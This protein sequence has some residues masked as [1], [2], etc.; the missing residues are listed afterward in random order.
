MKR[1]T[2][3]ALGLALSFGAATH[4]SA[5]AVAITNAEIHTVSGGVIQNGTI[6]MNGGRITAIGTAVAI[7]GN[8]RTID[9]TGKIVTPGFIDPSSGLGLSEIPLGA[10]GASDGA[11]SEADLGASFNPVWA[12]NPAA[13]RIP[14]TRIRGVTSSVVQPGGGNLFTG[15]GAVIALDGETV[16]DMI[17]NES[18]AIYTAMGETGSGRA[19]GSRAANYRRLHDALWDARAAAISDGREDDE[20]AP[21][22]PM[23][24]GGRSKLDERDLEALRG[25]IEGRVP[26]VVTA[27]R[28]S[29]IR[30]ALKLEAEFDIRMVIQGGAEGWQ[31][32]D[33]LAANGVPVI[34][35]ATTNLPTMDGL[36]AS[37]KNAGLM[38]AA[39]VE[40]LLTGGRDMTHNAG[41]AVANGLD[42]AAALRAVTLGPAMA[43]G[44]ASEMGSLDEGKIADV[45]MWSG[46]PFEL[47]T[48]VEHV[49]IG[50][51][52]MSDD[53]R[54]E[55]LFER[56][57][58]LGRYRTIR[59]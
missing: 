38:Q 31:V 42:H 29:D 57:R 16:A 19:G 8:A 20:D 48:S 28:A 32:A 21:D 10:P 43:F 45:V 5:Q 56:Y 24:E 13:T 23:A 58:D 44:V 30:L 55:Q 2:A 47:S 11:T 9:G 22:D 41:L 51:L 40:V 7:P 6:V 12:V 3:G 46:D 54:Q 39:G 34:V 14:I 53:S 49:F 36:G 50:G 27:N 1:G 33:E 17:R 26:L 4:L 52:E 18:A 37:L 59:R 35:S 25:V 15:Q